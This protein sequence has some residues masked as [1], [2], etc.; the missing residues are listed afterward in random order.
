MT[1]RTTAAPG[2]PGPG[3]LGSLRQDSRTIGLVGLAHGSSHFFHLLLPPLFPW[4]IADFGFSYSELSVLVSAFFIVSGV[5]QALAGFVVDRFGARP[6]MFAALSSF[7]VAGV[8][9][10]TANSYAG[11]MLAAIFAGLGNAPFHPVDFTILNKRLS[12]QRLGHGFSV[13]GLSGNLGWAAAPVFMAGITSATGS[14]RIACLCGAALAA[15]ILVIM[16]INR[17]ALDDRV[18]LPGA[19]SA[20]AVAAGIQEHPMAFLKLPSVWLCFSFF[21]WT[22]CAMSAIQSFSSPALQQLYGLPASIT[23]YVVTGYMLFGAAG[24]VLGGFLVGRVERLEKVISACLLFSGVL[25]ALVGTGWLPGYVALGVAALAGIGTGLA[26]PS[27][28]MLVKRAAPPGATGRVYGMVYSGLDLGFCLAAPVFGYMLD[29][30]MNAGV[31]FGAA[32][33]MV[34]SV[35]SAGFVGAGVAARKQKA[36]AVPA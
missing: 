26:G 27:R 2:V 3:D 36:A 19:A 15:I 1:T 28:D 30:H 22:T 23:A 20:K 4:L 5:G 10:G 8:I 14:W 17:D 21:F 34:L 7:A 32:V 12:P 18:S 31:F 13:H 35:V 11:L 29:H 16:V 33:G 24:M 25:L 9:A 6:I